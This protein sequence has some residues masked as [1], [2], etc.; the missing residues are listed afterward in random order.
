[1]LAYI[2]AWIIIPEEGKVFTG[3]SEGG[4]GKTNVSGQVTFQLGTGGDD[5][6]ACFD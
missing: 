6:P 5:T 1:M 3:S 4:T 2:V